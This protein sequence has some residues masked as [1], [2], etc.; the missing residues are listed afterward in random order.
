DGSAAV[1]PRREHRL[2]VV[3]PLPAPLDLRERRVRPA[4][5][6]GGAEDARRPRARDPAARRAGGDGA[7][8]AAPA[9]GRPAAA[10]G[11]RARAR[12]RVPRRVQPPAG[13]EGRRG[14]RAPGRRDA[15]ACSRAGAPCPLRARRRRHP[16]GEDPHRRRRGEHPRRR[17]RRKRVRRGGDPVHRRDRQRQADRLRP[18]R[19]AGSRG[20]GSG[21]PAHAEL[22]SGR[23][24]RRRF[25]GGIP[26]IDQELTRRQLLERAA[27]GG[28]ALTLP[29]FLAAC[30]GGKSAATTGGSGGQKQLAKTLNFSNWP[31]YIDINPKT[32]K[33]PSLD[34]FTKQTGVKI[35]YV[36]DINDN[37]QYFG[38]IE[39]P[40][41]QG[42]S[43]HRDIIVLTDSSGL[44]ARMIQLGWLEKLDKSAI[45]NMKNLLP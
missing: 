34:Q 10:G 12:P 35:S 8:Q 29:G 21:R 27:V 14:Q 40:L 38:K 24:L 22:E 31:L 16:P 17:R 7:P 19:P 11:P 18:E 20:G 30:G 33:H 25:H 37:D 13:H 36:E 26:M 23:D 43:I 15:G 32:K 4:A 39:G 28:A 45:P 3:R 5:A 41:S 42:Q 44:P 1:P 9:L 6:G 2:P